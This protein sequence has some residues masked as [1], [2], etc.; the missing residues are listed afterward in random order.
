MLTF[1]RLVVVL[2]LAALLSACTAAGGI[3]DNNCSGNGMVDPGSS[4]CSD[5][6]A[7]P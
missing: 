7:G 2:G 1:S 3:F 5:Y 4:Y 6:T